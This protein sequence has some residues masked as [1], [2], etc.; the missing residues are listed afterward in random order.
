MDTTLI[1][2]ERY[3]RSPLSVSTH[4]NSETKHTYIDHTEPSEAR[5]GLRG[6][7]AG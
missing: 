1:E 6:G 4:S 2:N 5:A 7:P 3:T